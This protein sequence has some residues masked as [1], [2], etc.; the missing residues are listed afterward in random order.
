MKVLRFRTSVTVRSAAPPQVV[1]DTVVRLRLHLVWSGDRAADDGFKLTS[2][3]APDGIAEI[4]TTFRSTGANFNGTF[5]DRSV[6]TEAVPPSVFVIHTDS[7]LDRK[8]GKPWEVRFIHRYDIAPE[9][10]GSRLTY[11]DTTDRMNYVPYWLK[12]WLRPITRMAIR[13]GDTQQLSNLAR[14][15]EERAV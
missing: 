10:E 9:G 4:G 2:L 12:P 14:L 8:H 11:T 7:R 5:H 13:K 3:E 1:Y 6:V 15:A